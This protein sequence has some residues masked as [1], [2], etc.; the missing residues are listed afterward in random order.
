MDATKFL[1]SNMLRSIT[2]KLEIEMLYGQMGYGTVAST[3]GN[4][5]VITTAEFASGIWIGGENMPIEIRNAAGT[6]SRGTTSITVV[7]LETRTLTVAA[8]PAGVVA[9]DVIWHMG[10]YGNEFAGIHKILSNTG[11]LFNISA[12]TYS[13]WKGNTYAVGGAAL[14][15]AKIER[16]LASAVAKGLEEDVTVYVNPAAWNDLLVE[17]TAKRSFDQS[18]N[19]AKV[20]DGAKAITFFGQSG[21]ISIVP[22]IYIKEGYAFALCLPEWN[23]V[24]S[25]DVSFKRPVGGPA[26]EF[27]REL[28]NSAGVELRCICDLAIF[29][30]KPG[31]NTYYTGIVNS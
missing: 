27:F 10:A 3:S 22:S 9:T 19:S 26:D 2:K 31:I 29:C 7:S 18:Y 20:E 13:L 1:V 21:M 14:S 25:S 11:T 17:Q 23:K 12:A 28:E 6:V 16:G 5:L 15:L 8:M 30:N 24:G 4:D